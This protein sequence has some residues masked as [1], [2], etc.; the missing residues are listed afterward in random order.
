MLEHHIAKQQ[1]AADGEAQQAQCDVAMQ[2]HNSSDSD[3]AD[4]E[5]EKLQVDPNITRLI[6]LSKM[7]HKLEHMKDV[8]CAKCAR[9]VPG[10][11]EPK[12]DVGTCGFDKIWSAGLRPKLVDDDGC[13]KEGIADI[14]FEEIKWKVYMMVA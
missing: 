13:P 10:A 12:C 11:G 3:N 4:D 1:D 8:L 2:D 5:P 9:N 6:S 7:G 14:W